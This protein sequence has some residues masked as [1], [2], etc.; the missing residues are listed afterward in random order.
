M[1]RA[2]VKTANAIFYLNP[3]GFLEVSF[4]LP[5]KRPLPECLRLTPDGAEDMDA[6]VETMKG[7]MRILIE[8]QRLR[9]CNLQMIPMH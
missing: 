9:R 6:T 4:P 1:Q 5:P 8:S 3:N 2:Y 7:Q